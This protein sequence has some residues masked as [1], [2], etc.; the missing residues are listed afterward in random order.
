MHFIYTLNMDLLHFPATFFLVSFF[1]A[2]EML[3]YDTI[4]YIVPFVPH[5]LMG[6]LLRASKFLHIFCQ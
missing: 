6:A 3:K 5:V 2:I 1:P 4:L